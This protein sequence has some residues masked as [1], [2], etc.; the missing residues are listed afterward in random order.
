MAK[1][2]KIRKPVAGF[3]LCPSRLFKM[4]ISRYKNQNIQA[5]TPRGMVSCDYL[6]EVFW[7]PSDL[8]VFAHQEDPSRLIALPLQFPFL[9]GNS[10]YTIS[11]TS[12]FLACW[13]VQTYMPESSLAFDHI[14]LQSLTIIHVYDLYFLVL[15]QIRRSMRFSSMVM[16]PTNEVLPGWSLPGGFLILILGFA[17]V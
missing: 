4:Q 14:G 16:E 3:D 13:T 1:R 11:P 9:Q 12:A 6:L 5:A 7:N 15:D 8:L 2:S 17:L 10:W